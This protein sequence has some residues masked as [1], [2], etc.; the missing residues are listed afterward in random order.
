M[1]DIAWSEHSFVDQAVSSGHP[2][3]LSA[4]LPPVLKH[5]IDKI[6]EKSAAEDCDFNYIILQ[7]PTTVKA[8]FMGLCPVLGGYLLLAS[9]NPLVYIYGHIYI[10]IAGNNENTITIIASILLL[11]EHLKSYL[12]FRRFKNTKHSMEF[13]SVHERSLN[14]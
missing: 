2:K 4:L 3:S 12:L 5:T 11:A 13:W 7:H 1:W 8:Y 10:P 14:S 6:A 9:I